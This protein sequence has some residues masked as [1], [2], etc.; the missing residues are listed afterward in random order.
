MERRKMDILDMSV[1]TE[2]H[3]LTPSTKRQKRD[4]HPMRMEEVLIVSHT[5]KILGRS[6]RKLLAIPGVKSHMSSDPSSE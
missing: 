3:P 4:A 1:P 6:R 2:S 5:G